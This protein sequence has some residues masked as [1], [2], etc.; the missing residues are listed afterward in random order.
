MSRDAADQVLAGL[1]AGHDRIA[2][3]MYALDSNPALGFLR[4]G[5]LTGATATRW[6]TLSNEVDLLWAHFT[7]LSEALEQARAVRNANRP[8]DPQWTELGLLLQEPA[9]G[10]NSAGLPADGSS[11]PAT[12]IRLWDLAQQLER[13]CTAAIAF[14]SEVDAAWTAVASRL[15]P[16]GEAL[17]AAT[18]LAAELGVPSDVEQTAARFADVHQA[19][20]A[21]PVSA[22]PGGRFGARADRALSDVAAGVDALRRRLAEMSRLRDSY[23]QRVEALRRLADEV[24]AAERETADTFARVTGKI[25][26]PNLPAPPSSGAALH[27]TVDGLD[28]LGRGAGWGRLTDGLAA[29]EQA[30]VRAKQHAAEL[31]DNANGLIARRDEL[32]G[33]LDA[34]RAKAAGKGLGEHSELSTRYDDAH[35][36]LFTAP[37]DLRGATR[38]VVAYQQT[39]NTL[40]EEQS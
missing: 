1:G 34:Y 24:V 2:A 17:D 29:A 35:A 39:L 11:P 28:Q 31:R 23:P 3:A 16:V 36:L 12:W 15:G 40:L 19:L 5:G 33:R 14:L 30:A 22:A 38:A 25:L 21:D 7:V 10:L 18:A 32:R 13:R 37:C 20:L 9:I 26:T 4:A 27:A 6:Q 8:G